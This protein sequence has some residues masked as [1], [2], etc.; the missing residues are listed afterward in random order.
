MDFRGLLLMGRGREGIL[1]WEGRR[2]EGRE[3]KG[4]REGRGEEGWGGAWSAP[5]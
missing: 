2:G 1:G 4:E 5:S 3:G